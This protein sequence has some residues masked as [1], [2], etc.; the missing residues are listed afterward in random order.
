[1]ETLL[2]FENEAKLSVD[3]VMLLF[4]AAIHTILLMS[5]TQSFRF[6]LEMHFTK[7][8]KICNSILLD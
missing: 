7:A 3:R 1:M 8:Y 5:L 6:F 4:I 2:N